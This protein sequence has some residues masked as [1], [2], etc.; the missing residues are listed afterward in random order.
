[1]DLIRDPSGVHRH[2]RDSMC[3]WLLLT[4]FGLRKGIDGCCD[5]IPL[6]DCHCF[7]C[8]PEFSVEDGA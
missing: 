1:M 3:L 7:S 8:V 2:C 6:D 5:E 4:G